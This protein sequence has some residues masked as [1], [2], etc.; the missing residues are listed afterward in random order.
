M[1][2]V[3]VVVVGGGPAGACAAALLAECGR[4]VVLLEKASFPRYHIGES[5]IPFTWYPLQRLGLLEQMQARAYVEKFSVQFA[6][7]SGRCSRPFYFDQSLQHESARTWQVERDDFD[8]MIL[9]RARELG[10]E[11]RQGVQARQ[12]LCEN[13]RIVGVAWPGDEVRARLVID[14]SGRDGLARSR[15]GW[16]DRDPQLDRLAMWT[17]V[18][19]AV[20]DPGRD[21][22]ATTVVML[23]DKGWFWYIPQRH[24]VVSIG[25]VARADY[26]YREGRDIEAIWRREAAVNPWLERHL[27]GAEVIA[28]VRVTGEYSYRSRY[29]GCDGLILCGDAL[30]FLDPVFSSG[31]LFALQAGMMLADA[32]EAAL[33]EGLPQSRHFQDYAARLSWGLDNMRK[34]V[35]AFYHPEFRM[36]RM[37]SAYPEMSEEVTQCLTGNVFRDFSAL[38][39]A[40]AE[41]VPVEPDGTPFQ[42]FRLD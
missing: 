26:L 38:H 8:A 39:R 11:V 32:T 24:D 40:M 18:R 29:F 42:S 10:V 5:L 31:L 2:E 27:A 17:Y 28:P 33:A 37:F 13:G 25:V 21:A 14:A 7:L 41:Q 1:P 23:P 22:G 36:S 16:M 12:L 15:F 30:A 20:R 4:R 35:C 34:L 9:A 3:D 6:G 19:G